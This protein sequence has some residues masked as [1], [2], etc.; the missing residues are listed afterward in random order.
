MDKDVARVH[1]FMDAMNLAFTKAE[2]VKI[3]ASLLS[4]KY[5][6]DLDAWEQYVKE[7]ITMLNNYN[8]SLH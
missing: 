4:E 1:A 2:L 8:P 7:T 3:L 5:A 6:G